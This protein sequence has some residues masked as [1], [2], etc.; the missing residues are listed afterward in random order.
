M[1]IDLLGLDTIPVIVPLREY[2]REHHRKLSNL[3]RQPQLSSSPSS[4]LLMSWWDREV[5]F[6][7]FFKSATSPEQ[8]HKLVGKV[9][10]QVGP[11]YHAPLLSGTYS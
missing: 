2:D 5:N 8:Q 4:Q 7:R 10:F 3:P 1:R 6:W 11:I 9:L